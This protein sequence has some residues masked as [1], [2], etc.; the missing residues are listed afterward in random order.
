MLANNVLD[1]SPLIPELFL[2]GSA[3]ILLLVGLFKGNDA[4]VTLLRLGLFFLVVTAFIVLQT[5]RESVVILQGMIMVDGFTQ[6]IKMLILFGAALV[7]ML[8][9]GFYRGDVTLRRFEYPVLLLLSVLGMMLLVSSHNLLAL[10][11]AIELMSLPL[12]VVAACHCNQLRSTE[13]GLKYFVLGALSSGL[14]LYGCSL[15]YG[16]S[17]TTNFDA[18]RTLFSAE[19]TLDGSPLGV[20]VGLILV[21]VALCFKVSAVPFHMWTPDV[22]EGAPTPVTAFFAV[23]PKVAAI[24]FFMQFLLQPFEGWLSSWQQIILVVSA[25]SMV[26]GSLGAIKQNNIKRLLAYSSIGHVGYALIGL[27]VANAAGVRAVLVY[28]MLYIVMSAGMFACVMMMKR[29]AVMGEA[30][31]RSELIQ[32]LAGLGKSRP[33]WALMIAI[34][35]FSMAGIPPLAGFFGKFFI[36]QSAVEAGFYEL[37]VLGVVMSVVAAFYYLRVIKIMYFDEPAAP[38]SKD[39]ESEISAVAGFAA[40]FN[41][42]FFLS[43]TFLF[44]AAHAAA[45]ALL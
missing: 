38:F 26:V 14:L 23:A 33:L 36:F 35:M 44:D 6:F 19:F 22:Y 4:T 32:D 11:M 12:Y 37:A 31:E 10:Y 5:S 24:G 43:P 42:L 30:C 34:F 40:V 29:R 41:L 15:I 25:A 27:V 1:L 18:L 17:G 45:M 20:L 13:S 7:F 2:A 16:F 3:V 28:V 39:V 21:I 8:S 9:S